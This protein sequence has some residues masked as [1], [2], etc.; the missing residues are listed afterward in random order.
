MTAATIREIARGQN[1]GDY[2]KG[3][4]PTR[5]VEDVTVLDQVAALVDPHGEVVADVAREGGGRASP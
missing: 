1:D 2:A 5:Y 4:M 3:R